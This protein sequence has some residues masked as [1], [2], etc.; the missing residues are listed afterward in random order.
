MTKFIVETMEE[1]VRIAKKLEKMTSADAAVRLYQ[2][3]FVVDKCGC[4]I[5][6]TPAFSCFMV[7]VAQDTI[8]CQRFH[9]V[10]Y[11]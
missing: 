9:W 7:L 10:V 6:K 2:F 5:I 3:L 8:R 4:F 11:T 1:V